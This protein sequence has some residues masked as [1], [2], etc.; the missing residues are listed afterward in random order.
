M[1]KI[2]LDRIEISPLTPRCSHTIWDS[3]I[4][5]F[6]VHMYEW[7]PLTMVPLSNC[8]DHDMNTV[9]DYDTYDYDN[10]FVMLGYLRCG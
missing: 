2:I 6:T 4:H 10:D 3:D 8:D 1:N 9:W 7:S 5:S